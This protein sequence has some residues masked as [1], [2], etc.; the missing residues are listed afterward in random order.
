M[1][2]VSLT[3]G[4]TAN[5]S[6]PTHSPFPRKMKPLKVQPSVVSLDTVDSKVDAALRR[7]VSA[8]LVAVL[9]TDL[10]GN[11]LSADDS[12]LSMLGYS[13]SDLPSSIHDLTPPE[14]R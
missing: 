9:F 6:L 5:P 12:F 2:Y 7:L 4:L 8:N 11:I 3:F 10:A 14:H 13:S 1:N